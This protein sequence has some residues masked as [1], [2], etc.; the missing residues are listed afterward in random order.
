MSYQQPPGGGYPQQGYQQQQGY[1]QQSYQ[2]PVAAGGG[3]NGVAAP[4]PGL[5]QLIGLVGMVLGVILTS[6]AGMSESGMPKLA[7]I[8]MMLG[9]IGL[10]CVFFALI[11]SMQKDKDHPNS[12]R[13]TTGII[14]IFVILFISI[15]G[16][17][18][19]AMR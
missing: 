9:S 2:A 1:A 5:L 13:V 6:I 11:G 8:G 17:V 3:G 18:G 15:G 12:V 4:A 19:M 14:A 10:I 7:R 16:W